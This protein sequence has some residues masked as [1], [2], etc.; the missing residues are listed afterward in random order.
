MIFENVP[1]DVDSKGN[2]TSFDS[3]LI[4]YQALTGNT[5]IDDIKVIVTD[6]S[7]CSNA[8]WAND[9]ELDFEDFKVGSIPASATENVG[10][11][12]N[13]KVDNTDSFFS[14]INYSYDSADPSDPAAGGA[15]DPLY[16]HVFTVLKLSWTNFDFASTSSGSE[17][18]PMN[19]T[20]DTP[21]VLCIIRSMVSSVS[22]S[23][24]FLSRI[25]GL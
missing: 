10:G 24:A 19:A 13:D 22:G 1:Q 8:N 20:H 2:K 6:D 12:V 5:A 21:G 4:S 3:L 7:V 15:T 9:T 14:F 25:H 18:P 11:F 16:Q 17:S 23:P